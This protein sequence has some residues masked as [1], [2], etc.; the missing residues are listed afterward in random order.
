[1]SDLPSRLHRRAALAY[2]G[3]LAVLAGCAP[4]PAPAPRSPRD[5]SNPRAPEGV[6]PL[7]LAAAA[8]PPPV[9]AEAAVYACPMHPEVTSN[10]PDVCPKCNMK[11]VPRS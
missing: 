3:S 8:P 7:A 10:A 5:P 2:L 11:L 1:M 6:S 4:A 9:V